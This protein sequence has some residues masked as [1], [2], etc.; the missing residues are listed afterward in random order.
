MERLKIL[1]SLIKPGTVAPDVSLQDLARRTAALVAADLRDLVARAE[2]A[3]TTRV[4]D[5]M[6]VTAYHLQKYCRALIQVEYAV[7]TRILTKMSSRRV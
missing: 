6:Y 4:M 7:G 1:K 3:A 2:I 5:T